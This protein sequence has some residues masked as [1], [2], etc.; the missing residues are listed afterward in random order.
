M[1]RRKK[2]PVQTFA[3]FLQKCKKAIEIAEKMC[4]NSVKSHD[5]EKR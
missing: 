1:M 4:Y 3:L 5:F 2:F